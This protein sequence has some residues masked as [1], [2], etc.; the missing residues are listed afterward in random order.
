MSDIRPLENA[1]IPDVAGLFQKIF[2]NSNQAA[3][4]T[5]VD[6]LRHV[7]IEAAVFLA[8]SASMRCR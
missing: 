5:L 4:P 3:P 7:Y 8:S 6:Y 1:D 2:R